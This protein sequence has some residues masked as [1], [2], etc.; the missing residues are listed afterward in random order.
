MSFEEK[1]WEESRVNPELRKALELLAEAES[2][3]RRGRIDRAVELYK[4]SLAYHPTADAHTYLG[5]MYSK[6]GRLEEAIEECHLAIEVDPDFGNPYNDIGC[7]LMQLGDLEQAI[8]WLEK[9]KRAPR[10]DP[11]HFPYTNLARIY[12]KRSEHGK[13]ASEIL[14]AVRRAADE[15]TLKR[16]LLELVTLLN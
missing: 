12:L 8:E 15:E 14:G 2:A 16:Q 4:N 13:A 9:A 7:Y 3:H 11:R 5:W 1:Y 10:Y 6:Q